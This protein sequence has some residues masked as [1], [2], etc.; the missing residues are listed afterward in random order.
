MHVNHSQ[1]NSSKKCG[2]ESHDRTK[3]FHRKTARQNRSQ[4]NNHH[5]RQS[6][7]W[8]LSLC[9]NYTLIFDPENAPYQCIGCVNLSQLHLSE[10]MISNQRSEQ[11]T[12]TL[13]PCCTTCLLIML[14]VKTGSKRMTKAYL[15]RIKEFPLW[16]VFSKIS[17][18]SWKIHQ[19][20]V[21]ASRIRLKNC[22]FT[23]F[24][25]RVDDA[26]KSYTVGYLDI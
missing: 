17:G 21:D 25:I 6:F 22:V 19:I 18:Y 15:Y 1:I 12:K 20:R 13:Q 14:A 7:I 2:F 23:N 8:Q 4:T 26:V 9:G 10:R 16:R 11:L 3:G 24:W 5:L